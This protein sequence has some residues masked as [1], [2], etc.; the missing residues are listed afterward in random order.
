MIL[1][2]SSYLS[3]FGLVVLSKRLDALA[4]VAM[5]EATLLDE[6]EAPGREIARQKKER[7]DGRTAA[8]KARVANKGVFRP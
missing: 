3:T 5:L 1:F 8:E 4:R 6:Q 2:R 7:D